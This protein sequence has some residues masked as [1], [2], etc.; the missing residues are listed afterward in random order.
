MNF[1]DELILLLKARYPIIFI[2]TIEEDRVEYVIRKQIKTNFNNRL[3]FFS[4]R[5]IAM[6]FKNRLKS[7]NKKRAGV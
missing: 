3:I 1:N 5:E 2:N 4:F 6:S 7:F